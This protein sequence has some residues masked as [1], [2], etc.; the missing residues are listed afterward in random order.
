[1]LPVH[2]GGTGDLYGARAHYRDRCISCFADAHSLAR[3]F[4]WGGGRF[5]FWRGSSVLF[6]FFLRWAD[7]RD[8]GLAFAGGL[9]SETKHL[10][11][12]DVQGCRRK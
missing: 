1:M 10:L 9:G 2:A 11:T 5:S 4:A 6:V 7:C 3:P 8:C 12:E